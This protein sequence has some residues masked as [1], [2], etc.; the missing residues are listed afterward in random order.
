MNQKALVA[1]G[2]VREI[3]SEI[4]ERVL[5]ISGARLQC[6]PGKGHRYG[7]PLIAPPSPIWYRLRGSSEGSSA[8][9]SKLL[10]RRL[11]SQNFSGPR[12]AGALEKVP[13]RNERRCFCGR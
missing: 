11:Q 8:A 1:T 6:A 13:V 4:A 9:Y 3:A 7:V 12:D 5:K 10:T 2:S